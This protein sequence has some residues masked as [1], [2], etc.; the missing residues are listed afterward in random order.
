METALKIGTILQNGKYTIVKSLGQ[1]SFGITYLAT[2][3]LTMN[4]QWGQMN[5]TVYVAIKEFYM[6]DLNNRTLDG[7]TVEGT[8]NTMVKNYRQ[9]FRK[10][11]ENLAKLN[12]PNI[13][14]V[15]D[16][17]DENNTTYYVME[18]IDGGTLD[19]YIETQIHLSEDEALKCAIEIGNAMSYMHKHRMIHLDLK[20]KNIM[21]DKKGHLYLI[22]FGLSKQYDENGEPESSTSIGLGT[23]GYAPLEQAN[24]KQDGTFP[25]TLD[26]YALGGTLLK[27]LTGQTP[28]D[29]STILNEGLPVE[30]LMRSSTQKDVI[31]IVVKMMSPMLK[32]RYQTVEAVI[33]ALQKVTNLGNVNLQ[34][35]DT[36]INREVNDPLFVENDSE[37][38]PEQPNYEQFGDSNKVKLN[39]YIPSM[40]FR[41]HYNVW[42]ILISILLLFNPFTIVIMAL[43]IYAPS[44]FLTDLSFSELL[45]SSPPDVLF[46]NFAITLVW[47]VI[48]I[49]LFY[50]RTLHFWFPQ[51]AYKRIRK[52]FSWIENSPKDRFL[53]IKDHYCKGVFDACYMRIAIKPIYK[54]IYMNSR[55]KKAAI[56]ANSE[57]QYGI[58]SLTKHKII[59]P[60][61]YESIKWE[62]YGYT[63][64]ASLDGRDYIFDMEGKELT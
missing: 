3:K 29:A 64:R 53:F 2:T 36:L 19:D 47:R 54:E 49:Y 24:F 31:D 11:A 30:R 5:A 25:V 48:V 60:I 56:V 45:F 40:M 8:E 35:D 23:P 21:R 42:I 15:F 46:T 12:H 58:L 38:C 27:M 14:K 13:V 4:G 51:L 59:L 1:G 52:K 9:K 39:N 61:R 57:C 33:M 41:P 10:E 7:T 62:K 37:E 34:N 28:P 20:P 22:D 63:L 16:V 44:F 26:I 17:F 18:Y 43:I 55:L 6:K 32:E 50:Y